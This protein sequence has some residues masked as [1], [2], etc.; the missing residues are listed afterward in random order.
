[1]T[2]ICHCSWVLVGNAFL[3]TPCLGWP[4]TMIIPTSASPGVGITDG[5][6]WSPSG[7]MIIFKD[8]DLI[9]FNEIS[10]VLIK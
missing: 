1:M 9:L 2:G 6:H 5:S 10:L 3:G 4:Q 8:Q 7:C